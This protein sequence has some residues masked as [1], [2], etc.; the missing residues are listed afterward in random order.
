MKARL[1]CH[2]CDK[3]YEIEIK[4]IRAL[5]AIHSENFTFSHN[6]YFYKNECFF[7]SLNQLKIK[8]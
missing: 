4:K 5:Q 1:F 8:H 3:H 7:K 6:T 2:H